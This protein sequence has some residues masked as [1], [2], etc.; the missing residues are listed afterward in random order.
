MVMEHCKQNSRQKSLDLI[1]EFTARKSDPALYA[2]VSL[3]NVSK[4]PEGLM[5]L[6][7]DPKLPVT[8]QTSDSDSWPRT[9]LMTNLPDIL[10]SLLA[11]ETLE[12]VDRMRLVMRQSRVAWDTSAFSQSLECL[13]TVTK[14]YLTALSASSDQDPDHERLL[15]LSWRFTDLWRHLVE[16]AV[17]L[18]MDPAVDYLLTICDMTRASS[19]SPL[20]QVPSYVTLI[21]ANNAAKTPA[22][23]TI[24]QSLESK[25]SDYVRNEKFERCF[26]VTGMT[27][28]TKEYF[29]KEYLRNLVIM[30]TVIHNPPNIDVKKEDSEPSQKVIEVNISSEEESPKTSERVE[31]SD[32]SPSLHNSLLTEML[33]LSVMELVQAKKIPQAVDTILTEHSSAGLLPGQDTLELV[34]GVLGEAGDIYSLQ[35]LQRI[36][37]EGSEVRDRVYSSLV[38]IRLDNTNK[39]WEG[40]GRVEAWVKLVELHRSV[41]DDRAHGRI[42][43]RTNQMAV[44]S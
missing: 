34:V 8:K 44:S 31:T 42:Q 5:E 40:G 26:I 30:K 36:L 1:E 18:N 17:G 35:S 2:L 3:N 6:V 25:I 19:S 10:A 14:E 24:K 7:C 29:S 28:E 11:C 9:V 12:P 39:L 21:T 38:G 16:S 32:P 4:D 33:D 37:P 13:E 23:E 20:S 22:R 15:S 43:V 41:W 27:M